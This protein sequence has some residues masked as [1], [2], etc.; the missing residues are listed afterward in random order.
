MKISEENPSKSQLELT[1]E[2]ERADIEQDLQNTAKKISSEI[3]I[4]GFR[5]GQAPYDVVSRHIGGEAKIYEQAIEAIVNRTAA[6]V[7]QEKKLNTIGRPQISIQ[8]MVPPFG[9]SYKITLSLMPS[10]E[11]GDVSKI[12]LEKKDPTATEEDIQKV[13]DNLRQMRVKE[14][15]VDRVAQ[16]GDKAVLDF[17]IK[18][19][20]VLIE[21][22][23]AK[24]YPLVIGEKKFIP[25]FE[26]KI[27]HMKAGDS[28]KFE[29]E[30]PK[31][32]FEKNLAGK[33]VQFEVKL[34]QVFE[35]IVPDFDDEFAKGMGDYKSSKE[36]REAITKNLQHEREREETEK[37]HM[38]AMER[39][40]KLSKVG[41]I[42]E[43]AVNEEVEK[44]IH[45]LEHSIT[46]QGGKFEDY[47]KSIKKTKQDLQ[48]EFKPK[49]QERL[50]IGLVARKFGEQENIQVSDD[51]VKKELEIAKKAYANQPEMMARLENPQYQD[52]VRNM[53]HSKKVFEKL[54]QTIEKS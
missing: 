18:K 9:I 47:L 7:L 23:S 20:N 35:R 25:G 40:V 54:A 12:K 52:Y 41:D 22:G 53:L 37:F 24:D 44:M 48:T 4:S 43:S 3:E 14:A 26:E 45:E 29:L 42:P 27:I 15:V 1:I 17:E 19:D 5:K 34:K 6:K 31:E 11:L 21:K 30:F 13:I 32:Y 8:K 50:K 2:L 33:L 39:L 36:M 38:Q 16:A 46:Q 51:D 10:I 49:A 28:K